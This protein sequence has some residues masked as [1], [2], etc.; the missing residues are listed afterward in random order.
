[1]IIIRIFYKRI[2]MPL[3]SFNQLKYTSISLGIILTIIPFLYHE[4][5]MPPKAYDIGDDE[6]IIKSVWL[7]W[8]FSLKR[9]YL[10]FLINF[11]VG[12]LS[13]KVGLILYPVTDNISKKKCET[14]QRWTPSL[15]HAII[16]V[17]GYTCGLSLLDITCHSCGYMVADL[18]I[19]RDI[20]YLP[21]HGGVLIVLNLQ[22]RM[23]NICYNSYYGYWWMELGN[24][25]AHSA[26]LIT[27]RSG[28]NFHIINTLA[29]WTS[30]CIPF[31]NGLLMWYE[32]VLDEYKYNLGLLVIAGVLFIYI[33]N[34]RWMIKMISP[35][36]EKVNSKVI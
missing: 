22:L 30:R 21:H 36:P 5:T 20:E 1:M 16:G 29:F 13:R 17:F 34:Y 18:I 12:V 15:F 2:Q 14:F 10:F 4:E 24:V 27:H 35:R 6:L 8:I 3:L 31:R 7:P 26:A 19:D 25:V 11:I 32:D 28:P 33:S 23:N 9:F